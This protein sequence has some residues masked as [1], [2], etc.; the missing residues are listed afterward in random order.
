MSLATDPNAG[1]SKQTLA[2]RLEAALKAWAMALPSHM[3]FNEPNLTM[4]VSKLSSSVAEIKASGWMYAYMHAVAEC[5]MFYLQAAVASVSDGVFTARRQSQA[6]E[7]LIVIMD[8][9]NQTGREGFSCKY[10]FSMQRLRWPN[11]GFQS[12]SPYSSFLTGR[13]TLRNRTFLSET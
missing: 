2:A 6:I 10:P 3:H 7:N 13:S 1:D 12:Y 8:A 11:F 5:G 4:A 9:I